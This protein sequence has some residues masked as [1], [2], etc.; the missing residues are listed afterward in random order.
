VILAVPKE[1]MSKG[2]E[3]RTKPPLALVDSVLKTKPP[4]APVRISAKQPPTLVP[5]APLSAN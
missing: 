3:V 1:L 5:A 2:C 4:S